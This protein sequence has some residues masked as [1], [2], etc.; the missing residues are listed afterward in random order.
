MRLWGLSSSILE[1][2][3]KRPPRPRVVRL[4][5]FYLVSW[6]ERALSQ[7]ALLFSPYWPAPAWASPPSELSWEGAPHW[8]TLQGYQI[9]VWH[10][11]GPINKKAIDKCSDLRLIGPRPIV[12]LGHTHTY[13][14]DPFISHNDHAVANISRVTYCHDVWFRSRQVVSC[15]TNNWCYSIVSLFLQCHK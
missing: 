15:I 14:K 5:N 13:K 4:P 10:F 12:S 8:N 2:L 6:R 1:A 7:R 11:V 3:C 9:R